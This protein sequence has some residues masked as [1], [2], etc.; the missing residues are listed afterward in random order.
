MV[1]TAFARHGNLS[2]WPVPI[3]VFE[4]GRSHDSL[5]R[6]RSLPVQ[7][8]GPSAD[9][10]GPQHC[11][12]WKQQDDHDYAYADSAPCRSIAYAVLIGSVV[13]ISVTA[14]GVVMPNDAH[15]ASL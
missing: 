13:G 2:S 10:G 6:V 8:L 15:I 7:G 11:Q 3:R 14:V 4:Q 5:Y 1:F 9:A 12:E